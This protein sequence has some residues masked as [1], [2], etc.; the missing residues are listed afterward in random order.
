MYEFTR[1]KNFQLNLYSVY[2]KNLN[3]RIPTCVRGRENSTIQFTKL[4]VASEF[5]VVREKFLKGENF[6]II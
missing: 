3:K 1:S 6:V 5:L 2:E 4:W